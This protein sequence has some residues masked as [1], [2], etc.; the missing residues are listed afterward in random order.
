MPV[1][2]VPFGAYLLDEDPYVWVIGGALDCFSV[3]EVNVGISS[4]EYHSLS[5]HLSLR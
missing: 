3:V 2:E 5:P 4:A 1:D